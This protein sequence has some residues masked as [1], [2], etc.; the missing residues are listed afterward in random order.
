MLIVALVAGFVYG[1]ISRDWS[2][3]SLYA[4]AAG[5]ALLVGG[6]GLP[7]QEFA[8]DGAFRRGPSDPS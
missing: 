7:W 8:P 6:I 3:V 2:G 5:V 4:G 1:L